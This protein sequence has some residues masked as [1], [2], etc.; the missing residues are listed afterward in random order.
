VADELHAFALIAANWPYLLRGLQVT[1][2]LSVFSLVGSTGL[3]AVFAMLRM[4]PLWWLR[5]PAVLYVDIVRMIPLVMV[6]FWIFFLI[7]I[8]TGQ[9]VLPVTTALIALILFN[10][11]YM[12]EVI[13]TGLQSVPRGLSEAARCSG[14]SYTQCML[15]V[16][17]PIAMRSML[18]ALVS[19]LI[20][21]IM[22][23]SLASIIGVTEFFRA[24]N[25][26]N[27]RL[28]LPYQIFAL[29][30]LVYFILSFS[31]SMLGR[32]LQ[33]SLAAGE[34]R[35]GKTAAPPLMQQ[36]ALTLDH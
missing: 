36:V 8:L 6:I 33:R 30:G 25:D 11:S 26:I 27:N 2:L 31:L 22:G 20:A 10:T 3:G 29:V 35:S 9:A 13:R 34:R 18:P 23:T 21:L 17:L 1:L 4:S 14:M 15:R 24:A 32:A 7:P 5:W 16:V 28:F 12:A 19:R